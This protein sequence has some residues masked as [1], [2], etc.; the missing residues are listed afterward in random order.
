MK[1]NNHS[2]KRGVGVLLVNERGEFLL[3]QRGEKARSQR[4]YWEN[5]GGEVESDEKAEDA[6]KREAKEELG[7]EIQILESLPS[8][9]HSLPENG[10]NWKSVAFLACIIGDK[11]PIIIETEKMSDFGWFSLDR[12]P[13]PLTEAT[14]AD[15]EHYLKLHP[16]K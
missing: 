5:I 14:R 13:E 3:A 9:S 15:F 7:I 11:A 12:F 16:N 1:P 2:V 6:A 8:V 10:E 4:G